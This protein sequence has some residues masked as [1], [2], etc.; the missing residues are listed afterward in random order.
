MDNYKNSFVFV[1]KSRFP[2]PKITLGTRFQSVKSTF[3]SEGK[4]KNNQS[5]ADI[6][7]K[8]LRRV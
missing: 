5:K 2:I 4:C 7:E 3:S 6:D 1:P 8:R